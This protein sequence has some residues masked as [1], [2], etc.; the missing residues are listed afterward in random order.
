MTAVRYR[1]A[2]DDTG[3]VGDVDELVEAHHVI[4]DH[5]QLPVVLGLDLEI[6]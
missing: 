2:H 5:R 4:D 3:D 6:G 1:G